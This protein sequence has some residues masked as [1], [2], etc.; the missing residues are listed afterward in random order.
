MV[1]MSATPFE[2]LS[3]VEY[4][5]PSDVIPHESVALRSTLAGELFKMTF[6]LSLAWSNLR[7][8]DLHYKFQCVSLHTEI[9]TEL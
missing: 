7:C 2:F 6:D 3:F 4:F 5:R 8:K 9:H 1:D